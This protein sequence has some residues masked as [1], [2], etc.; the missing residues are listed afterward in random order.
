MTLKTFAPN[1]AST[2]ELSSANGCFTRPRSQN[3]PE[4]V[5]EKPPESVGFWLPPG[6][7]KILLQDDD[8]RVVDLHALRT[9]LGTWLAVE[10]VPAQHAQ[11]I[12]RHENLKTT[13]RHY[14]ALEAHT[15]YPPSGWC[16]T[17]QTG[18]RRVSTR[19]STRGTIQGNLAPHSATR[20]E[21]TSRRVTHPN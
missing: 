21:M 4:I 2:T 18:R 13:M 11:R 20:C 12:L 7:A 14:M 10:G 9:T 17:W 1:T 8:G 3:P 5:H 15:F 6:A 19:V 16:Q